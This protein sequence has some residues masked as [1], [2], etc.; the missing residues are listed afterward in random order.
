M[1]ASGDGGA[2]KPFCVSPLFSEDFVLDRTTLRARRG[3]CG[4][5]RIGSLHP[6]LSRTLETLPATGEP[7]V[8]RGRS[9]RLPLAITAVTADPARHS[10]AGAIAP[11]ALV[12]ATGHDAV[13]E[14]DRLW[15]EFLTPTGGAPGGAYPLFPTPHLLFAG[16]YARARGILAPGVELPL[17][18][19]IEQALAVSAYELKTEM[20]DFG[21]HKRRLAGF[22]GRCELHIDRDSPAAVR[23][24]IH[25]L[26]GLAFY[27]GIGYGTG[28]GRGMVRRTYVERFRYRGTGRALAAGGAG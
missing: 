4:W 28:W 21:L 13:T 27:S 1:H 7:W 6:V 19:D 26:A 23:A 9:E 2:P 17:L 10:W 14:P 22:L 20:W 25:F 11:L 5:F 18:E 15:F 8:L 3:A 16:L 24:A 12:A